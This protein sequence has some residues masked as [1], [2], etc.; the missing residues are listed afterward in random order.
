MYPEVVVCFGVFYFMSQKNTK[1]ELNFDPLP[2]VLAALARGEM[3]LVADDERRENEGD[4]IV[5]AE[6]ITPAHINFMARHGRGLICIAMEQ[7]MLARLGLTRMVPQGGG[8]PFRTAFMESVDA[9]YGVSTGISAPDRARTVSVLVDEK[10]T[11][12]DLVRPGH[13]FPLEAVEGGVLRRPGHTE[14][15]VDLCRLAGLKRAGVICEVLREDGNMA[16]LDEL[17]PFARLHKLKATSVAAIIQHRRQTEKLIELEEEINFPTDLGPFRLRMYRS[18]MDEKRHLA[19][20]MG[21]PSQSPAPA[22]RV[23]SE[24][25]TGDA[26]GS[27]RCD[28]GPQLR[29]AMEMIAQEQHGVL[30]YMRQEGRGIGLDQKIRAYALQ[31]S[32]LDTVEANEQLGFEADGRD[33]SL[34]AQMLL[35]LGIHQCRLITN[36]PLKISGLETYGVTVAD[37]I[38][39]H[40]GASAHNERYMETKKLKMGHLL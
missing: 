7:P 1:L 18:I 23:H 26:F 38:P 2:E 9:R 10:S 19:L 30:L 21:E 27:L 20:V 31:E 4:L 39:L 25:L 14:A 12:A 33:Y 36:N 35:D 17:M 24:C 28:C 13:M 6:K 11:G 37:R 40:A 29:T 16:R 5:A 32:G 3:I 22:V 34:A 8:D 15:A